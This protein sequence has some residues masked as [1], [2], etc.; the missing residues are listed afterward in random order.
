MSAMLLL[1]NQLRVFFL[2]SFSPTLRRSSAFAYF[3]G[4][5]SVLVF[6]ILTV[7]LG[8]D[9]LDMRVWVCVDKVTEQVGQ[10]EQI[11]K[12]S[13]GVIFLCGDDA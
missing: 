11:A 12:S 13:N 9:F 5:L 1:A 4:L 2:F 8:Q 3:A 7:N 10:T 6:N